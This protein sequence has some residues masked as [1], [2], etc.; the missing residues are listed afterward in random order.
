MATEQ[1]IDLMDVFATERLV[2]LDINPSDRI[3][4]QST[5]F[6]NGSE[7]GGGVAACV[8]A[9]LLKTI[10]EE[11][12]EPEERV[13]RCQSD[14]RQFLRVR[15]EMAWSRA[16]QA[17][18]LLGPPGSL[19]AVGDQAARD[20][21]YLTLAEVCFCLALR[22]THLP[23]ELGRPDL[24][25]EARAAAKHAQRHGLA[26]I[27]DVIGR[28]HRAP[29]QTR[30]TPLTELAQILPEQK[31][32]MEPWVLIEVEEQSKAWLDLLKSALTAAHNA[33]GLVR[34]LPRFTRRW[35]FPIG[36][37]APPGSGSAPF[38]CS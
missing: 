7:H 38:R 35:V 27:L 17:V 4:R 32:E 5:D 3:V 24:F 30:L 26:L 18:T 12:L 2:W 14:A 28:V 8:P 11:Q 22:N 37:P 13:L 15:P 9:A 34:I 29:P 16:Q 36:L 6:P 21:A 25:A 10:E 19:A 33:A 23:A 31:D 20:A 1:Q